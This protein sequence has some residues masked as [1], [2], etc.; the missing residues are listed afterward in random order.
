MKVGVNT[1]KRGWILEVNKNLMEVINFYSTQPGKG[2]AFSQI[3]LK[4]LNSGAIFEK[5]FRSSESVE[6]V[7]LDDRKVQYLYND[8]SDYHFMDN[9]SYEQF[10]LRKDILGDHINFLK[11]NMNIVVRFHGEQPLTVELPP[12]IVLEIT[13]T[14]PGVKGNTVSGG[15]TKKATLETDFEINVPL[16]MSIGD[17]VKVDTRSGEYIERAKA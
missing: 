15:A 10:I 17:L 2:G 5:R 4:N 7:V 14:E 13:Y 3:K 9:E 1:V 16:F 8:G 12:S 11:D 6:R